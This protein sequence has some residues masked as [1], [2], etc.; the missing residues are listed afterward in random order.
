M[1]DDT[2]E[3]FVVNQRNF[4]SRKKNGSHFSFCS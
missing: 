1:P 2:L 3:V 4:T